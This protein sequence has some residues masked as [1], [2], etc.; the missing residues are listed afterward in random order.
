MQINFLELSGSFRGRTFCV[1]FQSWKVRPWVICQVTMRVQIY[2]LTTLLE[3]VLL[4]TLY[5]LKETLL[6]VLE[7]LI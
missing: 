3:L 6:Q 1:L 2:G 4:N 5:D 7:C